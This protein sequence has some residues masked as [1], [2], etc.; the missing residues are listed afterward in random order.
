MLKW[1]MFSKAIYDQPKVFS[2]HNKD[3]GFCYQIKHTI[4]MTLDKPV[5][6]PNCTIPPQLQ[7]VV[8]KCLDTWLWQGIIRLSQ[9]PYTCQLVIVHTKTGEIHLCMDYPKQSQ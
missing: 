6:L 3:L 1:H 9:G 4:P 8:Y 2:L 7:E 5:Y